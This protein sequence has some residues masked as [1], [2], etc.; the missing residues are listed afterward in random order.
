MTTLDQQRV[1]PGA[2]TQPTAADPRA[3]R[4]PT[5]ANEARLAART[6]HLRRPTA[7]VASG[8]AQANLVI[9]PRAQAF[10]FLLYCVRNP[11]PCPVLE[12]TEPGQ[13]E[14]AGAAPGADLRTD[15]PLYRV[16]EHGK[17]VAEVPDLLGY[18]RDDLVSFLLG[19]SLTF[20]AALLRAGIPLRHVEQCRNVSMYITNVETVPAGAFSGPLVVSMRSIPQ[21]QVVRA[22]QVTTRF[23]TMHGA[24][25]HVGDPGALGIRDL[26]HP[27]YGDSVEVRGGELPVFWA[28]GVTPQAAALRCRPP[29]MITHA[30]GYMFITD[31]LDEQLATL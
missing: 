13:W 18:W 10:D 21:E 25:V 14:P 11:K 2:L 8:F 7:G 3:G 20:E 19:C 6:G 16:F 29:L 26:S 27:D 17:L 30:P 5:A 15:V 24:P 28:C 23:P 4:P 31:I 22:V 12:V 9:V 1:K